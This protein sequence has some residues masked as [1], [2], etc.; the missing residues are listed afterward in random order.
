MPSKTVT[1]GIS[2][3]SVLCGPSVNLEFTV[4]GE[5]PKGNLNWDEKNLVRRVEHYFTA[6]GKCFFR[7]HLFE[8]VDPVLIPIEGSPTETPAG[9]SVNVAMAMKKWNFPVG[10]FAPIGPG[11]GAATISLSLQNAGIETAFFNGM[12]STPRTLT[13]IM[14]EGGS[15]LFMVKPHYTLPEDVLPRLQDVCPP[16]FVATGVKPQ[17]LP[18]MVPLFKRKIG[19]FRALIP[20]KDLIF[21]PELRE[22]LLILTMHSDLLQLN[23]GEA[24]AL[25][26]IPSE[27]L[28]TVD[29]LKLLQKYTH[30]A[31]VVVTLADRGAMLYDSMGDQVFVEEGTRYVVDSSGAGDTHLSALVYAMFLKGEPLDCGKA[32][33]LARFVAG[34]KC[35][36]VGPWNGLP[37]LWEMKNFLGEA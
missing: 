9:S 1:S 12:A 14:K 37:S 30:A 15:R 33:K 36:H 16:V 31:M 28:F 3:V 6:E 35:Q 7:V 18:L 4:C 23:E 8:D 13:V 17:D 25:L 27:S 10:V 24:K 29:N 5:L 22:Q 32:M 11:G 26:A 19:D 20:S 2:G 34:K 21:H